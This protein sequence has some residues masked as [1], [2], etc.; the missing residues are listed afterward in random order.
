MGHVKKLSVVFSAILLWVAIPA[1]TASAVALGQSCTSSPLG[2]RVSIRISGKPVIVVCRKVSNR[3]RW[4]RAAMQTIAT[5]TTTTSTTSTT[6]SVPEP[7]TNYSVTIDPNDPTLHTITIEGQ[8]PRTFILVKPENMTTETPIPLLLGFHGRTASG[9]FFRN[10]SQIDTFVSAMNFIAVYIDG[11]IDQ[12][13]SWNAGLCCTPAITNQIDDVG[14]VSTL[15]DY[16]K[17][18]YT[19]DTTRIWAVGHS[20]GGMMSYRLACD[21]SEKITAIAIV[22]GALTDD[23]CTPSKSVSILHIHG[24]TDPTVP[25]AGGGKFDT[26]SIV[27][28]VIKP[29]SGFSCDTASSEITP[30]ARVDQYLWNCQNGVQTKVMNYLDNGH[31]WIFDYTKIILRFLFAHPRK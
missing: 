28:S 29:N 9:E 27:S 8:Q 6:T 25:F 11:S 24:D 12:L 23:S 22:G 13:S 15:I 7:V 18:K 14:L 16:L 2:T 1:V 5:T 3:K 31:E 10:N 4:I 21:L 30:I 26:P 17:T 19:I 20:N